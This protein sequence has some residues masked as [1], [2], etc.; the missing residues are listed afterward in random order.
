MKS[1]NVMLLAAD[2]AFALVMAT[3]TANATY[4]CSTTDGV[5]Y[6]G[7]DLGFAPTDGEKWDR[8]D[9]HSGDREPASREPSRG[10]SEP[11][12]EGSEGDNS[13]E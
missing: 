1:K 2:S 5:K 8:R 4:R 3:S 9:Q 6:C 10:D 13:P 7:N 12:G 11:S